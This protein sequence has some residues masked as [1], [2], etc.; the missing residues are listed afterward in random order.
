LRVL[1]AEIEDE[2]HGLSL[3]RRIITEPAGRPKA[4]GIIESTGP[5]H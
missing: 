2:N 5:N 3:Q 4:A 1:R